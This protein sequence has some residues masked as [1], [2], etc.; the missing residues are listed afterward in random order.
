MKLK[1]IILSPNET[2]DVVCFLHFAYKR[3]MERV[4]L[5]SFEQKI[6]YLRSRI[7]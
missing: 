4:V 7:M 1:F 3:F 6:E 2:F 5:L